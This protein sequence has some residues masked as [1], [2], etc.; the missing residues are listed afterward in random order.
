MKK[1]RIADTH[2][3]TSAAANEWVRQ[4]IRLSIAMQDP[5]M[6]ERIETPILLFQAGNDHWVRNKAQNRFVKRVGKDGGDIR[7]V[8]VPGSVHEIFTMPNS[9]MAPYLKEILTFLQTSEPVTVL[10]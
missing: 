7:M 6:C 3:Q 2:Y 9:V 1:L 8:R 10:V 4:A 5:H